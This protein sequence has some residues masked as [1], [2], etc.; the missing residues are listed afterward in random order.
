MS[1]LRDVDSADRAQ[2]LHALG[3]A[4]IGGVIFFLLGFLLWGAVG[5][6][7][8]YITGTALIYYITNFVAGTM[9][10]AASTLYMSSGSSTPRVREYSLGDALA[11]KGQFADAADEYE[12]CATVYPEDPDPRLRLARLQ[13]DRVLD[14]ESAAGWFKQILAMKD[15][16]AGLEIQVSRELAELY[17]HKLKQPERALPV[18][19]RLADKHAHSPAAAWARAEISEIKQQMARRDE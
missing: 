19:A 11:M 2:R 14:Y 9:G 1:K 18:L 3:Y 8:G 16:G 13:R 15:L 7:L 10:S 17:S 12:R 4:A 5:G 6:I